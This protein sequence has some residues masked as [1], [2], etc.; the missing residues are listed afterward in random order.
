[1]ISDTEVLEKL[2]ENEY[3]AKAI[4]AALDTEYSFSVSDKLTRVKR[5]LVHNSVSELLN[6]ELNNDLCLFIR[7]RVQAKGG[8]P[9]ISRGDL[10]YKNVSK[11]GE[12]V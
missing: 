7:S 9:Y 4:D 3:L 5:G 11:R 12:T 10:Y 1:M 6:L 8:K 2:L